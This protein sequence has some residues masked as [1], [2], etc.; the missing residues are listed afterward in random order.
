[1]RIAVVNW[2][3]RRAGGTETYLSLIIPELVRLGHTVSFWHEAD[4]PHNREQIALPEGVPAWH[5]RAV[6][7]RRALSALREWKP[8][9]IY[10]H[11]LLTPRLEERMLK[12][13]PATFFAHAYYGTC[14]SGAKTFKRPTV[15]PCSRQFGW[16]CLMHYYPHRCGGWNP[17]TMLRLY[18]LQSKR[19]KLLRQYRAIITHSSHMQQEYL[20]H[21]LPQDRVVNLAY[22]AHGT[23]GRNDGRAVRLVDDI[24]T[25]L[26]DRNVT[27]PPQDRPFY[28][29]M[30]IGRMDLLKGGRTLLDAVPQIRAELDRPIRLTFA[31]EGPDRKRWERKAATV[32]RKW[33]DVE[34]QFTGW[35]QRPRLD[36][37]YGE[38][39][40]LVFPSMWPEPFGLAGPEAGLHG[41]PVAAFDV[42]GVPD[43]LIDGVN[44]HLAPGNPPTAAGIA[45]AVV[46]CLKDPETRDRLS[47]GAI[48][49]ARQF[50]LL[51]HLTPLM[52]IFERVVAES[53]KEKAATS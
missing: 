30:F 24:N 32:R 2:S 22:Y 36:S 21:G 4:E 48:S 39:D 17:L 43:W 10:A 29:L 45:G 40:L 27:R 41:V 52:E 35:V 38:C 8:D 19:L 33:P 47:R 1:M 15:T 11:S 6:G 49:T 42:G 3:R 53:W 46:K 37:L 44:G 7:E 23:G 34:I 13:A 12:I 25:Q 16:K 26:F 9:L 5:V 50:N 14:I 28:N 51:N 20:K 18:R 31:G